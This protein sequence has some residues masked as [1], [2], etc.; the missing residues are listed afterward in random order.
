MTT[1]AVLGFSVYLLIPP[2]VLFVTAGT[3]RWPMAWAY[4]V[5]GNAAVIGSRLILLRRDPELLR[6]RARSAQAV[7]AKDW[8]RPL[9]L[10][11]AVLGPI[12]VLAVAGLDHRLEWPPALSPPIQLLS[13]FLVGLGN[14]LA[15]WAMLS[16]RYFSAVVRIQ[17]DRGHTVV[18][19]G[20]YAWVRH[21]AYLGGLVSGLAL[22]GMLDA[23]WAWLP[24]FLVAATLVVRTSLEDR[25]LRQELPGYLEYTQRVGHRLL[26]LIW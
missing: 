19:A 5:M 18:A 9:A 8:D 17:K 15:V 7:D 6:E 2:I 25:T 10:I 16:N 4:V 21:P 1:R 13:L 14:L 26:P 20:P 12:I 3:I 23:A 22:P 24:S 11:V